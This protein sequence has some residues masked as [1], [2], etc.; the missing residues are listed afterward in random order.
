MRRWLGRTGQ[1]R[2]AALLALALFV[3][4]LVPTGWMPVA[5][6]Q[7]MAFTL[8]PSQDAPPAAMAA[9]HGGAEHGKAML[10]DHPCAFAGLGLSADVPPPILAVP[11]APVL[12]DFVAPPVLGVGVGRGLA[13]PPPPA[14]GPPTFA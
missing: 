5:T 13:A 7:G 12:P 14:T 9:H 6:A 10:P 11:L 3:R 8:C 2:V 1:G 4:A